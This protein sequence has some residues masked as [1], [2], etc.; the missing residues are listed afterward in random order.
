MT[1]RLR[2]GIACDPDQRDRYFSP[3]EVRRL[4]AFADV[5]FGDFRVAAHRWEAPEFD[6]DAEAR[7]TAFAADKDVLLLCHGAPRVSESVITASPRLR[8][9]GDV[10]GDRFGGRVDVAAANRAG[11]PVVDTS[12]SSSWPV[13]EWALALM[14]LGL[15]EH[16]RF[17]DLIERRESLPANYRMDAPAREL[18]GRTVG[19][20]GFG[21]IAW[22]LRE[23]LIPFHCQVIAY[24]PFA[25]R[26]L[27]DALDIDFASLDAVMSCGITVC[28]APATPGTRGM[29]DAGALDL[30]PLDG[31][32]VNVS[33]G[34]VVDTAALI[35]RAARADA[36]FALDAHDPEPLL[37][38]SPLRDMRNV[39]LSPHLAGVTR[40]AQ[41][42]FFALMID[43]LRRFADGLEPR[44]QLTA[45]VVAGREGG[46]S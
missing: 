24:D 4:E 30:I 33:R 46:P 17:R 21:H 10:E 44:A 26:E 16:G 25:P 32:F 5:S 11:I 42:R 27:A 37:R 38:E 20:I 40:E 13:A 3:V 36:W 8:F 19:L 2:V 18:S 23:F 14:M 22:R 41:P 31:V 7:L 39:F 35:E 1:G 45:R 15:R 12:H 9:I 34:T 28:L 43:E 6:G 29:I